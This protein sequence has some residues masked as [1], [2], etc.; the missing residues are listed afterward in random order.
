MGPST[1]PQWRLGLTLPAPLKAVFSTFLKLLPKESHCC[2]GDVW[3]SL[4]YPGSGSPFHSPQPCSLRSGDGGFSSLSA[5]SAIW[6]LGPSCKPSLRNL[7]LPLGILSWPICLQAWRPLSWYSISQPAHP[8]ASLLSHLDLVSPLVTACP[9]PYSCPLFSALVHHFSHHR[10]GEPHEVRG[11]AS[12]RQTQ[13][14][15]FTW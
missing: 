4:S 15:P 5:S 9:L 1:V 2:T 12:P 3:A 7:S 13:G 14:L 6:V 10:A 11:M 8:Q